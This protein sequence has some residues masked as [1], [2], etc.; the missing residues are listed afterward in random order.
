MEL[1]VYC[2][3]IHIFDVRRP[4][5]LNKDILIGVVRRFTKRNDSGVD[6]VLD[7]GMIFC[8]LF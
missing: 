2:F 7:I 8:Q 4:Q 5:G 3:H 6:K 1:L